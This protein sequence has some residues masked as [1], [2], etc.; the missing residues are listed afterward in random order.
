MSIWGAVLV[1]VGILVL[2]AMI[3]PEYPNTPPA[4][5]TLEHRFAEWCAAALARAWGKLYR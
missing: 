3:L 1:V 4:R 2:I 5:T